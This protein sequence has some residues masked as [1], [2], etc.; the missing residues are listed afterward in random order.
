MSRYV[1]ISD[2]KTAQWNEIMHHSMMD[3]YRLLEERDRVMRKIRRPEHCPHCGES[4]D[5]RPPPKRRT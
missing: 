1:R 5:V 2:E 4:L 3:H